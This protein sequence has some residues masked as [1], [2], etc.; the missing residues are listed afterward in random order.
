MSPAL[1]VKPVPYRGNRILFHIRT[2]IERAVIFPEPVQLART[3]PQLLG[4]TI[5]VDFDVVGFYPTQSFD[6]ETVRLIGLETGTT[7]ELGVRAS[8]EGLLNPL[9]LTVSSDN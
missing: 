1:E 2:G 5:V 3:N 9:R 8:P 4:C 6:R 7:Y